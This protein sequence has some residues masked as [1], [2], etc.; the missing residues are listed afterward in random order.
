[1]A[2]KAQPKLISKTETI[3]P[4]KAAE[5]LA[6]S[7]PNRS[8]ISAVLDRYVRDL[9]EGRWELTGQP[10]IFSTQGKLLD[11]QH[12]LLAVIE[13]DRPLTTLVVRNVTPGAFAKMDIGRS[14]TAG[15]VLS[16]S[17]FS[18]AKLIA[19]AARAL[20]G[21][22]MIEHDGASVSKVRWNRNVTH[23]QIR[24]YARKHK[25]SL[26]QA[27]DDVYSHGPEA[28]AAL[29]PASVFVAL[30]CRFG[31][32]NETKAK[33]FFRALVTGAAMNE[34]DPRLRLRN[35][36]VRVNADKHL[37]RGNAWKAAITIKAWNA[38][39]RGQTV[40]ALRW[41]ES[42]GMPKIRSRK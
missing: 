11:G 29:R 13:A 32:A 20:I 18:H 15:D 27:V 36:L 3:T 19:A 9:R 40:R 4:A 39:L 28:R 37:K 24:D 31:Q 2:K 25:D 5:Y 8:H 1:M 42:E 10:I 38:W 6:A 14:R 12:R 26:Y 35:T 22:E 30:R 7:G 23:T 21:I 17:N 16:A 34:D 33:E 41:Q